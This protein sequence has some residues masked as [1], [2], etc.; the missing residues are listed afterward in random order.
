MDSPSA[1][2]RK[3]GLNEALY[4]AQVIVDAFSRALDD[5][6]CVSRLPLAVYTEADQQEFRIREAIRPLLEN[7]SEDPD[8]NRFVEFD[9]VVPKKAN[10]VNR[11]TPRPKQNRRIPRSSIR[12]WQEECLECGIDIPDFNYEALLSGMLSRSEAFLAQIQSLFNLKLPNLCQ[13]AYMMSFLCIPDLI[14][15]LALILSAIIKLMATFSIGNIALSGFILGIL[16]AVIAALLDYIL[17]VLSSALRPVTCLIDSMAEVINQIPTKDKIGSQLSEEEYQKLFKETKEQASG[18]TVVEYI[19]DIN[20][21]YSLGTNDSIR[22]G[23]QGIVDSLVKADGSVQATIDDL[24]GMVEYLDCE[25]DRS[26]LDIADKVGSVLQLIQMANLTIAVIDKKA[27]QFTVDEMCNPISS[28]LGPIKK[29]DILEALQQDETDTAGFTNQDI[30]EVMQT[31]LGVTASLVQD[32][33]GKDVALLLKQD[34][35]AQPRIGIYQCSLN[36]VIKD[37]TLP[38]IMERAN[39]IVE[40]ALLKETDYKSFFRPDSHTPRD[41]ARLDETGNGV[42]RVTRINR[43]TTKDLPID[44]IDDISVHLMQLDSDIGTE[45]SISTLV[46]DIIS[47]RILGPQRAEERQK[48]EDKEAAANPAPDNRRQTQTQDETI[49]IGKTAAL[50][51]IKDPDEIPEDTDYGISP[52]VENGLVDIRSGVLAGGIIPSNTLTS[53][54]GLQCGSIGNI[55]DELNQ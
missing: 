48:R 39:V 46:R 19:G 8:F 55:L 5:A 10:V 28:K 35:D 2:D 21:S 37:Y 17:A 18:P 49:D 20:N 24:L 47:S 43:V 1:S 34:D 27:I 36:P 31:A 23:F 11:P 42:P 30:A 41:K 13:V 12:Q 52:S 45:E 51:G 4:H 14:S 29:R 15:I 25:P 50:R 44:D 40:T 54:S 7:P 9:Y 16:S 53:A 26:G 3:A 22:D 33:T 38:A 32:D 6:Q